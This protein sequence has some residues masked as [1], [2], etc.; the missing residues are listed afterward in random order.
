MDSK[1]APLLVKK[2][3]QLPPWMAR[4]VKLEV[5]GKWSK[6]FPPISDYCAYT[7][8][9]QQKQTS[10]VK[11]AI[12]NVIRGNEVNS[13]IDVWGVHKLCSKGPSINDVR[14]KN[15]VKKAINIFDSGRHFCFDKAHFMY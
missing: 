7:E 10:F 6:V 2:L 15:G 5:C 3:Q 1:D 12:D 8:V 13:F 4:L 9:I 14:R 11:N